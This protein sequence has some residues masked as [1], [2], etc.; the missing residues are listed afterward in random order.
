MKKKINYLCLLLFLMILEVSSTY[1]I[2]L[3]DKVSCGHLGSFHKK[4]PEIS[5]WLITLVQIIVP[6]LL[7]IFGSIDFVKALSSQKDDE[8]K[9]GQQIFV[10]RVITAIM[11]FFVVVIVKM[12]VS[13]VSGNT[14]ESNGIID[15]IE[16]FVNN[17]C[18]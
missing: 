16:C 11:I 9:K 13:L 5:S 14:A 7:V 17:K 1:A 3:N 15:C 12:L 10:K 8:I 4:I 6:V 18:N 2:D